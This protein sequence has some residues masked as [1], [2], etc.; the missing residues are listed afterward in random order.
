VLAALIRAPSAVSL[1]VLLVLARLLGVRIA[2]RHFAVLTGV[3]ALVFVRL[4]GILG[5]LLV[6]LSLL[7]LIGILLVRHDDSSCSCRPA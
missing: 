3:A 6:R 5:L 7:R 1:V 2:L 4:P